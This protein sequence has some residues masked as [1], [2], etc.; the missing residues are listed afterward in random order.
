MT[1]SQ[2][3]AQQT[4]PPAAAVG[5]VKTGI[6]SVA[7]LVLALALACCIRA[8]QAPFPHQA[9]KAVSLTAVLFGAILMAVPGVY[10]L[11][12]G[13]RARP[14]TACLLFLSAS[15]LLLLAT[16][17]FWI[18][19]YVFF[20]AD[21]WIWSESDFVN[22]MLKFSVG[23]PIYS[24]PVNH[25]SYAYVPGS[26]LLTYFLAWLAGKP[27]SIPAYRVI[28]VGY[29]AVAAFVANL[30]CRRILLLAW[31]GLRLTGGWL[32]NCFC[33][34]LLFLAATNTITNRYVHN[35]HGDAL[36]QLISVTA[37]YVLL[38]Y[39]EKRSLALL[40]AMILLV[41]AAWFT[42]QSLLIWGVWYGG[43]LAVWGHSWKRFAIFA[44]ASTA[45]CGA[46]VGLCYAVWGQP[47][48]Y[49]TF[50]LLGHHPV[51]PLRSFQHVLDTWPYYAAGLLGGVAV[52]RGTKPGAL[53]G[54]W[55]VWLGLIAT[56]TYTSG[57]AWMLNHIGPGCLIATVWFLA[58]LASV[59]DHL[60]ES[61]PAPRME[62]WVR[63]G[64]VAAA[65]ALMFSGMGLVR[66]PIRPISGDA[67]RY[68]A[69]IEAQF[70]GLPAQDVLLDVGTWIYSRNRVIVGDRAPGICEEGYAGMGDRSGTLARLAAKRYSKILVRGLHDPDFWYENSLW[71]KPSGLRQAILENYRETGHIRA[72]EP[73]KE[74]KD[75][76]EDPYLSGEITILEPRTGSPGM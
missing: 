29:T 47:F 32:W 40:A 62:D 48:I 41:P 24:P 7:V 64:A 19:W 16:Y 71:P 59:W 15:A 44:A 60:I 58:G 34:A 11:R 57:I 9:E 72:I 61:R 45:A 10:L 4:H 31:P 46:A 3:T 8:L 75:R 30:C 50:S 13:R 55:L 25:D 36:A 20:R 28:Q 70:A 37:F 6:A 73:P 56:E 33:Y 39:V 53:W 49:W 22:D 35:L 63:V 5:A 52:L 67:Y 1:T 43:F 12:A 68:A 54:A 76:L 27:G 66:I 2:V 17:F 23:Y 26:Q 18:G 14:Q 69:D 51:L 38:L 74:V 65:V 42:K 21:I